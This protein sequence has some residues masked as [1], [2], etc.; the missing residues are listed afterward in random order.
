MHFCSINSIRFFI[1]AFCTICLY[2]I[3][4]TQLQPQYSS[5]QN[6][7]Y[8]DL[9]KVP[10]N[11]YEANKLYLKFAPR[12][13]DY[14]ATHQTQNV[15]GFVSYGFPIVDTLNKK[16]GVHNSIL[17]FGNILKDVELAAKHNYY[18]FNLWR[19]VSFASNQP[20][21]NIIDAYLNTGFFEVVEPIYKAITIGSNALHQ[22]MH[23]STING[24]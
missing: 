10:K 7:P 22:T 23:Y 1:L 9:K 5:H 14:I 20:I 24:I 3:G 6:R 16:F 11:A 17:L 2:T 13:A 21:E 15:N 18:G 12:L 19:E 4:F 8:I